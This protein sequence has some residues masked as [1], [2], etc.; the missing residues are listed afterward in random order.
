[1]VHRNQVGMGMRHVDAGEGETDPFDRIQ[2]LHV[3]GQALAQIQDMPGEI[4]RHVLEIRVVLA[5]NDQNMAR[6]HGMDVQER[7]QAAV[8]VDD[9]GR[10]LLAGNAAEQAIVRHVWQSPCWS[11]AAQEHTRRSLSI[12]YPQYPSMPVPRSRHV[13]R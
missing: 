8:L 12:K 9:V 13:A 4:G 7:E 2:A 3:A 5:G 11:G 1:M 6:P 10:D